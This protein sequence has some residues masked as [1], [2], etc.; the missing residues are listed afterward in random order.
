[1]SN[2]AHWERLLKEKGYRLTASRR[3]ILEA[4]L[5]QDDWVSASALHQQLGAAHPEI[6]FSTVFR[7]LEKLYALGLLCRVDR[8]N[9]SVFEYSLND[10]PHHHHHLICR[11]CGHVEPLYFC[12]LEQQNPQAFKNYSALECKFEVYGLCKS[13]TRKIT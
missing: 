8:E 4:L 6:I 3:L 13:C 1:M 12:P 5:A 2:M 10:E 11:G 9:N 7:N